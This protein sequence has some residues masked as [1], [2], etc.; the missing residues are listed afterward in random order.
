MRAYF[1]IQNLV[2]QHQV[3][4]ILIISTAWEQQGFFSPPKRPNYNQNVTKFTSFDEKF[5]LIVDCCQIYD[6]VVCIIYGLWDKKEWNQLIKF[7]MQI[8][9][10]LKQCVIMQN[11]KNHQFIGN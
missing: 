6:Y 2:R 1:S 8:M 11:L 9:V 4:M 3:S 7:K 5:N 10:R